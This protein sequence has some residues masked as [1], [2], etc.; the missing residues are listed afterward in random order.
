LGSAAWK[1]CRRLLAEETPRIFDQHFVDLL[2]RHAGFAQGRDDVLE[3]VPW[4]PLLNQSDSRKAFSI[5]LLDLLDRH[6]AAQAR[7]P[8]LPRF[9][10]PPAPIGERSSYGPSSLPGVRFIL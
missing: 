3:D 6:Y 7:I 8:R 5:L 1:Q 10:H 2:L 4:V 9:T